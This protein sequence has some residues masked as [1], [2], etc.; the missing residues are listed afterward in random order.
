M[1][2][3]PGRSSRRASHNCGS[4]HAAALSNRS[5]LIFFT[6]VRHVC[7][8]FDCG[9]STFTMDAVFQVFMH[10]GVKRSPQARALIEFDILA[11]PTPDAADHHL[12]TVDTR[13]TDPQF[14]LN[15]VYCGLWC[16]VEHHL[17]CI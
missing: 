17:P 5:N 4:R 13:T 3:T 15:F 2:Q 8:T 16:L 6:A 10:T 7:G 1:L 11:T 9:L 14:S 12:P